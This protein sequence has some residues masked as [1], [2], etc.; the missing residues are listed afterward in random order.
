V[1]FVR[2]TTSQSERGNAMTVETQAIQVG[3]LFQSSWGYDQTNV[4]FYEVVGLTPSGKSVRVRP[5]AQRV[6]R[7][8]VGADYVQAVRGAYRGESE[9]RRI[10]SYEYRGETEYW[11]RVS[12]YSS[13]RQVSWEEEAFQTACGFGH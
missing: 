12:S 11:F 10:S 8:S 3:D 9:T 13:A 6:V 4:D 1:V 2:E 7:S 5:V